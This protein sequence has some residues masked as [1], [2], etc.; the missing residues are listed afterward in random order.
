MRLDVWNKD[1]NEVKIKRV[2]KSNIWSTPFASSVIGKVGVGVAKKSENHEEKKRSGNKN[3]D[4][5]WGCDELPEENGGPGIEL[6]KELDPM[7]P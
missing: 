1:W 2:S 5:L 3:L 4:L 7:G 6:L